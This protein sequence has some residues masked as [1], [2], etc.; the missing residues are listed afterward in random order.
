[1]K[2]EYYR[3]SLDLLERYWPVRTAHSCAVG[4]WMTEIGGICETVH[5]WEYG[6]AQHMSHP[7]CVNDIKKFSFQV[8]MEGRVHS[9]R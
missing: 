4:S 8:G 2:P 5:L 7:N 6:E 1:M 3:E 9:Y